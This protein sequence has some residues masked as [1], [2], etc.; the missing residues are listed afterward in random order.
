MIKSFAA[1]P[2]KKQI[3]LSPKGYFYKTFAAKENS[4]LYAF[5]A[6][7]NTLSELIEVRNYKKWTTCA[8]LCS[9]TYLDR[10][11]RTY[12]IDTLSNKNNSAAFNLSEQQHIAYSIKPPAHLK[13]SF[14]A[15]APFFHAGKNYI[16]IGEDYFLVRFDADNDTWQIQIDISVLISKEKKNLLSVF[17]Y[18]RNG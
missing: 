8:R 4:V 13:E 17:V 15:Y 12:S 14:Y 2:Y 16:H 10:K 5:G 6:G 7:L 9:C 18:L 3:A 1:N 11:Y